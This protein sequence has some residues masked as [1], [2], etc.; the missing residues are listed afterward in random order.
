M[1]FISKISALLC[2]LSVVLFTSCE[3]ENEGA[4]YNETA[5]VTFVSGSLNAITVSA[6]SPYAYID[7]LRANGSAAESGKVDITVTVGTD[8][9]ADLLTVGDYVFEEG[10]TQ[11]TIKIDASALEVGVKA[12]VALKLNV[13]NNPE[14]CISATKV[15]ISKDYSWESMGKGTW[16]DG[17]ICAVFTVEA[18]VKW[19]VEVEKAVGFDVYRMV[20]AYGYGVCPWTAE[21]EVKINPC[22]ITIDATDPSAVFVADA[23]MGIDWGYGEFY[24][25]SI[26]GQLSAS[27]SYVLGTK[28]G[29]IIDLGAL[30]VG[31][32]SDYG[33]YI[34]KTC[35]LVLPN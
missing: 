18:G 20:N 16:S 34:A 4:I 15:T 26:Y 11:T 25:G 14:R 7:V 9:V 23:S 35:T 32:G 6:D 13:E 28:N 24:M 31:M 3:Q 22:Y 10:K 5:G 33:P 1:K 19:E 2:L 27:P 30:Y 29:N 21:S 12:N 17:L 8:T